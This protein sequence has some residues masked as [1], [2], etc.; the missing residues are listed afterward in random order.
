MP[1]FH[2]F[3][4][5]H[6]D[7]AVVIIVHASDPLE[8]VPEFME[9]KGMTLPCTVDSLDD[10]LFSLSGA[11]PSVLPHTVVLNR[12]GEIIYNQTGSMTE[13]LLL[14]LFEKAK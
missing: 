11:S 12:K 1:I 8:D 5:E 4:E 10:Y 3:A 14:D 9:K 13:A 6:K 2:K 7:D